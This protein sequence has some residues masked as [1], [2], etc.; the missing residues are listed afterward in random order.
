MVR[1][2]AT[3]VL[4]SNVAGP[5]VPVYLLGARVLDILPIL[6]LSANLGLV[7]SA[8]SYAGRILLVVTAD[9]AGFPDLEALMGGM[10]RDWQALSGGDG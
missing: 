5:P 3:N 8:F 2:R 1:Q 4:T 9:A 10:E 6:D 7:L